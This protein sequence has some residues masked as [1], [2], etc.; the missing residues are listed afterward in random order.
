MTDLLLRDATRAAFALQRIV[1]LTEKKYDP[2]NPRALLGAI[3]DIAK[4]ALAEG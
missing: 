1:E 4:K 3:Q 2:E